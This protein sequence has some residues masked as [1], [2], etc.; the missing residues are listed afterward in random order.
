M[1]NKNAGKPEL[2]SLS[3]DAACSGNPGVL[4]YRGV[5]TATGRQLFHQGAFPLGTINIG[6]FLAIVHALAYLKKH[7][8]TMPVYSDS[9]TAIKWVNDKAIKTKLPRNNTT[10]PLFDLVDR[11]IDWLKENDYPN[12]ILKWETKFWGEIPADFGRK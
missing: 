4:E 3:V 10:D 6:E 12:R 11:A 2:N 5:E 1:L 8:N 9:K 7:N